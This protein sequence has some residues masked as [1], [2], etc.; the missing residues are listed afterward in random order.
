MSIISSIAVSRV[1]FILYGNNNNKKQ[2]V[3]ISESIDQSIW[4]YNSDISSS[5]SISRYLNSEHKVHTLYR[6]L[7]Y[8]QFC[9]AAL[10]TRLHPS[11]C[12]IRFLNLKKAVVSFNMKYILE[13]RVNW[14]WME[15]VLMRNVTFR[16]LDRKWSWIWL[17]RRHYHI[18]IMIHRS[19]SASQNCTA[20]THCG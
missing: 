8:W 10:Q 14:N 2:S 3:W 20:Q 18:S 4:R 7:C 6:M 13:V 11:T 5:D 19:A 16:T 9:K 1:F 15:T 12:S 17:H